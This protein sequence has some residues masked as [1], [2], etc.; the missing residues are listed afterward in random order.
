MRGWRWGDEGLEEEERAG[1]ERGEKKREGDEKR[2]ILRARSAPLRD[3]RWEARG[4]EGAGGGMPT[5][6]PPL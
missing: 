1:G 2:T 5:P 6:C 3:G 4:G